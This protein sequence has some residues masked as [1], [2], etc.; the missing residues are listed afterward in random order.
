MRNSKVKIEYCGMEGNGRNLTEAKQ[1]VE[2]KLSNFVRDSYRM[3]I[4]NVGQYSALIWRAVYGWSYALIR[5]PEGMR[6]LQ[7]S[8]SGDENFEGTLRQVIKHLVQL[9][10]DPRTLAECEQVPEIITDPRDRREM[11]DYK[12][13]YVHWHLLQRDGFSSEDAW[14]I[15]CRHPGRAEISDPQYSL[16]ALDRKYG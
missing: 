15:A 16:E 8:N 7:G 13:T 4:V 12:R 3:R 10:W 6:E 1:D 2:R 14:E 9:D 11:R 5:D